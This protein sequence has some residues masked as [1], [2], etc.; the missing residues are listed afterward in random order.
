MDQFS[1][2]PLYRKHTLDTVMSSFWGFYKKKFFVLFLSSFVISLAIQYLS[3]FLNFSDLQSTTDPYAIIS[4]LKEFIRPII[5]IS[6]ISLVFT[7]ILHYYIIY[8]PVDNNVNIFNSVYKSLKY[9]IPFLIIMILLAFFGSVAIILGV[10]ILIIGTFFAALY[11][12]TIYLFVLPVLMVEGPNIGNA[13][14][15][16][17]IL[18]HRNFW[19]NI[20]WVAIFLVILIVISFITSAIVLMPFS[21]SFLKIF[22]NPEEVTNLLNFTSNPIY[23][24]LSALLSALYFPLMPI[25]GVILY[26]NGRAREEEVTV[27]VTSTEPDRVKVEDL[28]AK[29]YSDDHPEN[30]ENQGNR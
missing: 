23:I 6:L 12:M 15:R 16:S 19:S 11:V 1:N 21:G 29:P 5:Y 25:L 30:P 7:V 10:F 17:L 22:T 24:I 8:N 28:Y 27:T 3:S 4:K 2:H 13:I 26:F 18:S 14:S 20:G 9:L